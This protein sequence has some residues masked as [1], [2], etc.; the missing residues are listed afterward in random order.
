MLTGKHKKYITGTGQ[1]VATLRR[2]QIYQKESGIVPTTRP[3]RFKDIVG[4]IMEENVSGEEVTDKVVQYLSE[5]RPNEPYEVQAYSFVH[6]TD[7]GVKVDAVEVTSGTNL[8]TSMSMSRGPGYEIS[9][10]LSVATIVPAE[11]RMDNTINRGLSDMSELN[12]SVEL[13]QT[14]DE[15]IAEPLPGMELT[16]QT[17]EESFGIVREVSMSRQFPGSIPPDTSEPDYYSWVKGLQLPEMFRSSSFSKSD[18]MR[19]RSISQY[20]GFQNQSNESR[21]DN[22]P[23]LSLANGS[24]SQ[25]V[26]RSFSFSGPSFGETMTT[27]GES[28]S[29]ASLSSFMSRSSDRSTVS[30]F[31]DT[32]DARSSLKR[33][34]DDDSLEPSRK[35]SKKDWDALL[36][37]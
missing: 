15:L 17:V 7:A 14:L 3:P 6:P 19:L 2:V 8:L 26:V 13:L 11:M 20:I 18:T 25:V 30:Y 36:D 37:F 4:I 34:R 16:T 1:S 28:D 32:S 23:I 33:D 24:S 21:E 31:S 10:S 12:P 9:R 27:N 22:Q 35:V 29:L 5:T